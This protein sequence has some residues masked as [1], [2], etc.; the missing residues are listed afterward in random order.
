MNGFNTREHQKMGQEKIGGPQP[1][2]DHPLFRHTCYSMQSRDGQQSDYGQVEIQVQ[3]L[4]DKD[5]ACI[6]V[7]LGRHKLADE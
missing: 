2:K 4:L 5:G 6:H 7:H 1:L 3:R